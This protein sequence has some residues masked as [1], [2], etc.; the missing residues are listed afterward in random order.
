MSF[1]EGEWQNFEWVKFPP[2]ERYWSC[3]SCGG[4]LYLKLEFMDQWGLMKRGGWS[5]A[6]GVD[7][8]SHSCPECAK[9][10]AEEIKPKLRPVSKI[11][12]EP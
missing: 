5:A 3:D 10:A 6:K 1:I 2:P 4:R 7:G 11:G 12:G 8:W 9:A